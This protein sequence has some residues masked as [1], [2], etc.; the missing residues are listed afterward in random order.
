MKGGGDELNDTFTIRYRHGCITLYMPVFFPASQKDIKLLFSKVIKKIV[1]YGDEDEAVKSILAWLNEQVGMKEQQE[2]LLANRY[3]S[4][5]NDLFV[6]E[7]AI[8]K[9]K[10]DLEGA[11]RACKAL[12][13]NDKSRFMDEHV[14]PTKKRLEELK[15]CAAWIK[16]EMRG[17]EEESLALEKNT[18]KMEENISLI[19]SLAAERKL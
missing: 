10:Q 9:Q 3:A 8:D 4:L 17:I 5:E 19:E 15:K 12:S 18:K 2:S 11:N 1:Y 14:M 6:Q 7:A 16:K 13:G